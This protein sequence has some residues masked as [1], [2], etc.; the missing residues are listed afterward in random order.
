MVAEVYWLLAKAYAEKPARSRRQHR[1]PH[2]S[3]ASTV[4][5]W[6]PLSVRC[7][8]HSPVEKTQS[9]APN[10]Q[11]AESPPARTGARSE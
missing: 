1:G 2:F 10:R 7:C 8:S 5:G 6:Q 11:P 4:K 3:F 9:V